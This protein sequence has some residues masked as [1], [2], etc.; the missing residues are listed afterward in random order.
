ME[1]SVGGIFFTLPN[2]Q[3]YSLPNSYR[4][5]ADSRHTLKTSTSSQ[6]IQQPNI[7]PKNPRTLLKP[8][9]AIP[10]RFEASKTGPAEHLHKDE[11]PSFCF[12]ID[13]R[14]TLKTSTS[15]HATDVLQQPNI[16]PKNPRTLLKPK[17]RFP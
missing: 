17:M 4:F 5:E 11:R 2:F 10:V 13:S 6:A 12:T 15:S 8:Q 3:T 16:S 7:S 1:N 14:H 9:D